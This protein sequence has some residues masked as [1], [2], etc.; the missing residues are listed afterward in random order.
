MRWSQPLCKECQ[1]IKRKREK[2]QKLKRQPL[3]KQGEMSLKGE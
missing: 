3:R 2:S 1:G